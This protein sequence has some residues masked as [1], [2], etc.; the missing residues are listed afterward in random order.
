MTAKT[1]LLVKSGDGHNLRMSKSGKNLLFLPFLRKSLSC[2]PPNLHYRTLFV[3]IKYKA[4]Q[5]KFLVSYEISEG[6]RERR[7]WYKVR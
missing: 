5:A 6:R 4:S 3:Y 7:G 2:S 1:Y